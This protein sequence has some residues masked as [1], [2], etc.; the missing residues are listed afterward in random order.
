MRFIPLRALA[1]A[2]PL[3]L[4]TASCAKSD[5]R[6]AS[7]GRTKDDSPT[8]RPSS[9]SGKSSSPTPPAGAQ[10][11]IYCLAV[12]GT[13]HVPRSIQLRDQVARTTGMRDWYVVH[14]PEESTLYYGYYRSVDRQE[15][16]KEATR[17][18]NDREKIDTMVDAA[19]AR[20][21][22]NALLVQLAAPDPDAP[23]QWDLKAAP[24]GNYWSIQIAAYEGHPDRKKYAVD[25]VKGFRQNGVPAYYH[26]GESVSSVCI[27]AWPRE[28]A[29][30]DLEPAYNDP[31][32]TRTMDQIMAQSPQDLLVVAPGLPPV[33]KEVR[34]KSGKLR[35]VS[36]HLEVVD[37]TLLA[38]MKSYPHHYVNGVVEGMKTAQGVQGKPSFLVKIPRPADSLLGGSD[39]AMAGARDIPGPPGARPADAGALSGLP[40]GLGAGATRAPSPAPNRPPSPPAPPAEGYGRLRSLED[41]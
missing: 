34:T 37:P 4:L 33:N 14:G 20:P 30:G 2:L 11:T 29:R 25:A 1:I 31:N 38:T 36:P 27:G 9:P 23:P 8:P 7:A 28:A 32:Q 35:A 24:P 15:D 39:A 10:Y 18:R 40:P 6:A 26:H 22:R 5:G 3:A 17:A 19:G 13:A 16:P 41:R 21:F 12:P